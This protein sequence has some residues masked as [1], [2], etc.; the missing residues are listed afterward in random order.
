MR[1]IVVG[2]CLLAAALICLPRAAPAWGGAASAAVQRPTL[3]E[4]AYTTARGM[5]EFDAG[6]LLGED[7]IES[8]A[9]LRFGV[10]RGAE[11]IAAVSPVVIHNSGEPNERSGVGD[12][13]VGGKIWFAA[14]G[15]ALPALSVQG[16]AKIPTGEDAVSSGEPDLSFTAI[17]TRQYRYL[18]T[19]VN[20]GLDL[21]GRDEA[22]GDHVF[23][24]VWRAGVSATWKPGTP[25]WYVTEL[26]G[27][28]VP[29]SDIDDV[30][31][32]LGLLYGVDDE[33]L[34]DGAVRLGLTEDASDVTLTF[35][36]T[37]LFGGTRAGR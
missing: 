34:L 19:D 29:D 21:L 24:D 10:V 11:L 1:A 25:F 6:L 30:V 5:L 18:I 12:L 8:P 20:V 4:T 2:G 9:T 32:N 23:D 22:D 13:G 17:G 35:G 16:L 3:T 15:A 33:L 31:L 26:F 7:L 36:V 28:F 37:K 27:R 14:Q